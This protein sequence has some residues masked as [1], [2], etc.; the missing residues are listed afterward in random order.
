MATQEITIYHSPDADDAFMFYGMSSGAIDIPGY[1]FRHELKD[2]ESLNHMAKEGKLDCTAVSV[3]AY[4]YL[5]DLY[6]IL[7]CGASM[8]GADYGP[9]LVAFPGT[10]LESGK[11]LR[12][13]IPGLLTSATL[14]LRL[15]LAEKGIEAD[16]ENFFFDE[17]I[18]A[19]KD[20]KVD[21]GLIIHEGQITH[22]RDGLVTLLDLGQWWWET[23]KLPLPL[24]VNIIRRSLGGEGMKATSK[25]LKQSI[26]YSL[27]H[28]DKALK[29]ALT[30]GRGITYEEA[31][32][33]VEMYVNE[34]TID[35]GEDGMRSIR[36]FLMEAHERGF[37]PS[38]IDPEFI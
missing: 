37:I 30:Y 22:H 15:W 26:E 34:R 12:L 18:D 35:I 19:V 8:G 21:A 38:R 10:S 17:V 3:H 33:F 6:A 36:L 9:R 1:E 28:R 14:S 13:A 4:A 27:A 23:R 29:Y 25:A 16:L 24:G 5:S 11:R 2:I 20:K 7:R 32:R 31:D